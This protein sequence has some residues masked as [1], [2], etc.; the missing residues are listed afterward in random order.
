[1]SSELS[2]KNKATSVSESFGGATSLDAGAQAKVNPVQVW[3]AARGAKL[4]LQL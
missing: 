2:D 1:M 3:A 4:G